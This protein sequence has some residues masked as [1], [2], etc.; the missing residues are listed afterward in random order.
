M[1]S[2][3]YSHNYYQNYYEYSM[4]RTVLDSFPECNSAL[5]Q[6][7]PQSFSYPTDIQRLS[8]SLSQIEKDFMH[9]GRSYLSSAND[10]LSEI[11]Q[12]ILRSSKPI[13]INEQDEISVN[14]HRG[15]WANKSEV[16]NWKGDLSINEYPINQ[17]TNPEIINKETN[18]TIEY[19]Q[20]LAIKY[21]RPPTPPNP[22]EIIINQLP[23]QIPN[24]APPLIIRQ[25]PPRALTPEPLVIR[26]AP[27]MPPEQV[28]R[29]VITISGKKIPPP[30]RKVIVERLPS[31]PSKPQSL[32]IERWLPYPEVKRRVI[33]QKAAQND[34]VVVKPRNIIVQWNTPKV[35]IKKEFKYLGI[36]RANPIDYVQRYGTTLRQSNE[37]PKFVTDIKTPDGLV[38]AAD[39]KYNPLH[40]LYG[41]LSALKLIDLERE[42][43]GYYKSYLLNNIEQKNNYT[44]YSK[45]DAQLDDN[46]NGLI[47]KI[48]RSVDRDQNGRIGFDEAET[49]ISKLNS[50]LGRN[51]T[52]ADEKVFSK[53]LVNNHD[54]TLDLEEFRRVFL[55]VANNYLEN[56][57]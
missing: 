4:D 17:D 49:L 33:L 27:P 28:G 36:V 39:Y 35:T 53:C 16:V 3:N 46:V 38:L 9:T 23:D 14:G 50:K 52:K 25:Q 32:L 6:L 21:L 18:Q 7:S 5:S 20:E 57:K 54:R 30:P 1:K 41:D 42:G 51:Y 2:E 43:L 19:V 12:N 10:Y 44:N 34:P 47:E 29:K 26:E 56:C 37:L 40:E 15:I 55:N 11:E 13:S 22:G 8:S 48:F 45:Y 24:P 31:L